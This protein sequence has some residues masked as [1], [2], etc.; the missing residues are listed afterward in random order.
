MS[1]VKMKNYME[2]CVADLID[3][4]LKDINACRCEKCKYDIMAIA[5]NS[6]PPKYVVTKKG[7]LYTKLT[8][9]QN[10]SDVDVISA[11]TKA[12]VIVSKSPRHDAKKT[13]PQT[14]SALF[15]DNSDAD[16]SD[17]NA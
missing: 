17:A 9:L 7:Q 12:S 4:V 6:L 11:I 3:S 13:T 5:L 14:G 16:F 1:D 10:Q 8:A 2:D 15:E